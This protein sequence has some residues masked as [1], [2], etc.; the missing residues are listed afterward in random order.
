MIDVKTVAAFIVALLSVFLHS[1]IRSQPTI[2]LCIEDN[3]SSQ[4]EEEW[5][6]EVTEN[7]HLQ[8]ALD[9][10]GQTEENHRLYLELEKKQQK[11]GTLENESISQTDELHRLNLDLEKKQRKKETLKN[12]SISQRT[13]PTD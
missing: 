12:E 5:T 1:G 2:G 11:I 13:N 8:C 6:F 4:L 7:M 9:S 10:K 3:C